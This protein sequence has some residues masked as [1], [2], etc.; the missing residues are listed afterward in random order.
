LGRGDLRE[1]DHLG[2]QGV[3]GRIILKMDLQKVGSVGIDW[4]DWLRISTDGGH[5]GMR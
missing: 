3:D 2:D 4:I 1:R 5:L